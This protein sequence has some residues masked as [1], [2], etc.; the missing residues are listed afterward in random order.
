MF[1]IAVVIIAFSLI[2]ILG[3]KEIKL[4]YILLITAGVLGI[5]SRI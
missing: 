1:Q 5:F 2:P 4:S 3:R